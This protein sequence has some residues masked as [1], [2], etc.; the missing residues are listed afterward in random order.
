MLNL[1]GILQLFIEN[2]MTDRVM[3]DLK[4]RSYI[5][6][7]FI[8]FIGL[9]IYFT[10]DLNQRH[11][12][13]NLFFIGPL[14]T[15]CL[16]RSM[17]LLAFSYFSANFPRGNALVFVFSVLV[18]AVTWGVGFLS[19]M[20]LANEY[21]TQILMSMVTAGICA[22]GLLFFLYS[23]YLAILTFKSNQEYWTALRNEELL[24]KQ[25]RELEILTRIDVLTGLFNRRH[26]EDLFEQEWKKSLRRNIT[27]SMLVCDLDDFKQV[28][29]RYGHLAGDE[30]IMATAENLK[31]VFKRI[32][33]IVCRFG[34]EEFV[35]L[36]PG[37][38]QEAERLAQEMCDL[39]AKQKVTHQDAVIKTTISI[40]LASINPHFPSDKE[41]LFA[42]AD[43]ALYRAKQKGKNQV[44]SV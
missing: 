23:F 11:P 21:P 25:S 6:I 3:N 43:Q 38:R 1:K 44:V 31:T 32:T 14:I 30:I 5:G 34:G 42:K 16:F 33:D 24:R 8:T 26:F 4:T 27:L 10:Y 36:V 2:L 37:S 19:I 39:Q 17:H 20:S 40:G 35:I 41:L 9:T 12:E 18:T 13:L 28:N 22:A 15:I 7:F 29:D